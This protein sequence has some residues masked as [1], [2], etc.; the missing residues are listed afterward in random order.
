VNA[1]PCEHGRNPSGPALPTKPSQS[2]NFNSDRERVG[3]PCNI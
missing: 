1:D 2:G 3:S